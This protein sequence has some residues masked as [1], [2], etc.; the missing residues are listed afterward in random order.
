MIEMFTQEEYIKCKQ[1]EKLPLKCEECGSIFYKN[2]NVI[3]EAYSTSPGCKKQN[4][5]CSIKCGAKNRITQIKTNCS[6]C[7]KEIYKEAAQFK[8]NN[9]HFCSKKCY[10]EYIN[11]NKIKTKCDHCAKE[12]FI[13]KYQIKNFNNHF[14]NKSCAAKYKNAHTIYT[15]KEKTKVNC[16]HCNKEL[17]KDNWA[18]ANLKQFFCNRTCQSKYQNIHNTSFSNRS[19][20]E[21]YLENQLNLLYPNLNFSFNDRTTVGGL[22]LDI[23]ISSLK[24]A[25]ELNGI[26]HYEP[27]YGPDQLSTVHKND[28]RKF[29]FC[30][31]NNI[32]LAVIDT[33]SQKNFTE[34]S[35]LKYLDIITNII[36]QNL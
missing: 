36:N 30:H 2:K 3:N 34:K 21:I 8:N 14:C 7:N 25:F 27:I 33:T 10:F 24:L 15:K 32:G 31:E 12:I 9:A 29:K 20:L 6:H 17:L 13:T 4:K 22:E 19:K 11:I 23:Y 28:K 18:I 16:S 35:S 26:V 1:N 5:F